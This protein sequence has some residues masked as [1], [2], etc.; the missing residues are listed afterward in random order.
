[1]RSIIVSVGTSLL[2]NRETETGRPWSGWSGSSPIP[3]HDQAVEYLSRADA[4]L[5]SAETNTLEHLDLH[6]SDR[7]H[8]L[9]S[10][11][12][13]GRFCAEALRG[14]YQAAGNDGELHEV[15]GINYRED[16]FADLGLR[17]L[18]GT[19]FGII[20][21]PDAGQV[22]I[23]ATGGFKAELAYLNLVG[24]LSGCPVHYIHERFRSLV[25]LPALPTAWDMAPVEQSIE[26]FEWMEDTADGRP[27]AEVEGRLHGLPEIRM[28]VSFSDGLG[29][30]SPAGMALY[31]SYQKRLGI[32]TTT[33]PPSDGKAPREKVSLESV[34]HHRPRGWEQFVEWLANIDFVSFVKY[35]G[36]SRTPSG[37]K[38]EVRDPNG[39]VLKVVYSSDFEIHFAVTTTAR[40]DDQCR[41]VAD[42]I[43]R[44][45]RRR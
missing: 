35:D 24:L 45:G 7:L 3:D 29:Y 33:W 41:H 31:Q 8:W 38:A 17:S 2:T 18:V 12:P 14:H 11:T 16:T 6:S 20:R 34:S 23:C 10:D 22:E 28:L 25:T 39:G 15:A 4:A 32:P 36:G 30:L 42:Y 40:G 43:T 21:R 1:M 13:E 9:H 19:A 37:T 44:N 27:A 5:A 26:F